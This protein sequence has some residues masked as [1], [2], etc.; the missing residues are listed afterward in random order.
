MADQWYGGAGGAGGVQQQWGQMGGG[1]QMGGAMGA[2][3]AMGG[4]MGSSSGVG[5]VHPDEEDYTNEPPLLKEL[6]V[7]FREIWGRTKSV[8]NPKRS[9]EDT[10]M[11]DAD[12]A[13]PVIFALAL[14]CILILHGK[15]AFGSIY[16]VFLMGCFGLYLVL[17]LLSQKR[18]IGFFSVVS[19]MG[20]GLL[21]IIVL[22][23]LAVLLSMRG[24]LGMICGTFAMLWSTYTSSRFFEKA[25]GMF[26]HRL[27]IA[28][29]VGLFYACF[30]LLTIF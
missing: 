17:S 24:Y 23:A 28:Y 6:G 5:T 30:I 14:A 21:P 29:P 27:I 20:Y 2:T 13:G 11:E 19:I 15:L 4:Q 9:L 25:M 3:G 18:E 26:E 1:G 16:G 7:D 8:L 10:H 12:L 22:A